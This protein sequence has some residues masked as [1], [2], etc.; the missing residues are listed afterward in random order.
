MASGKDCKY[1][2]ALQTTWGTAIADSAA[3]IELDIDAMFV[4][5]DLQK[6][7]QNGS[8]GTRN[9][10]YQDI[11]V[12]TAG[13]LPKIPISG[14]IK[15]AEIA[16]FLAMFGQSVTEGATTPFDKT[17]VMHSSSPDFSSS[18]GVFATFLEYYPV[19]N[20]S[21]KVADVVCQDI[22]LTFPPN[23]DAAMFS[24]NL[25]GRGT[26]AETAEP[27]GTLTRTPNK[28]FRMVSSSQD[29]SSFRLF[30]I[31]FGAGAQDITLMDNLEIALA[32]E[33]MTY[34]Q[35]SEKPANFELLNRNFTLKIPMFKDAN[36]E[37]AV[38]NA[39]ADTPITIHLGFGNA[40][41]G[42]VDGDFDLTCTA[43]ITGLE[44]NKDG[45]LTGVVSCE[46]LAADASSQPFTFVL[47][48]AVD[49]G[50]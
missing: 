19:S 7:E 49:W 12:H 45:V 6:E 30:Q 23:Q 46:I 18:A 8:H 39:K 42:S 24:A 10:T 1:L 50:F 27:T 2:I 17:I 34:G 15:K 11:Q 38:T 31:D 5:P 9:R 44:K 20:T 35:D 13:S 47:A 3:F 25:V 41:P 48:D 33:V 14:K 37:S 32:Q 40:T 4:D 21:V 26:P 16:L 28:F 36:F 22:T 29:A 43:K